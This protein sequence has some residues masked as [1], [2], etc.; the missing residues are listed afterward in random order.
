MGGNALSGRV[1]VQNGLTG[2]GLGKDGRLN[3]SGEE[4]CE[5]VCQV[6]EEGSEV[7]RER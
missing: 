1:E 6:G 3:G 4:G 7:R 5:E 2:E